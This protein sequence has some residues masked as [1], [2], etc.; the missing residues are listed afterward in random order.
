MLYIYDVLRRIP[1]AATG[2]TTGLFGRHH[3]WPCDLGTATGGRLRRLGP[4][5]MGRDVWYFFSLGY[6]WEHIIYIYI[7][8]YIKLYY[9]NL[10][11]IISYYIILY[12]I[13]LYYIILYYII[14]YYI[15]LYLYI[16]I[17][18]HMIYVIIRYDQ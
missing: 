2:A 4:G 17:I 12:Y 9:I 18:L 5:K 7:L 15:I 8:D 1:P 10:Y 11:Y 14:L 3:R 6:H 16:H 13:I